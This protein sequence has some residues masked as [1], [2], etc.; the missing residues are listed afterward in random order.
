MHAVAHCNAAS[1]HPTDVTSQ[2]SQS[3]TIG[4]EE[5]VGAR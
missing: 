4:E 1:V 5:N 2:E 3:C